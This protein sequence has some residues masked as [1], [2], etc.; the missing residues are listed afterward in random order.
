MINGMNQ[1]FNNMR[2]QPNSV[3]FQPMPMPFPNAGR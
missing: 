1:G 2:V 3:P